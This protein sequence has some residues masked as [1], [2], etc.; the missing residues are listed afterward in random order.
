MTSLAEENFDPMFTNKNN[1]RENND[2]DDDDEA[3]AEMERLLAQQEEEEEDY[4]EDYHPNRNNNNNNHDRFQLPL[5]DDDGDDDDEDDNDNID[6]QHRQPEIGIAAIGPF[7]NVSPRST[8]SV[9][10]TNYTTISILFSILHIIYIL[11][12]RKQIYLSLM[13][14]TTS[15]ISYILFGN[16]IIAIFISLYHK[17]IKYFLNGLRFIES[18][19]I[20]DSIRWNITESIFAISMF[21]QEINVTLMIGFGI[22]FWMKCLH[23]AVELRGSHLR[24]TEDVFYYLNEKISY[25]K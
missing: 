9:F 23:W 1:N 12:T 16:T 17:I 22:V 18:E 21:R 25:K 11:R 20:A 3:L 6:P 10:K 7:P 24:M 15:R 4:D 5:H 13:Y 19:N 2:D 14:L 8:T